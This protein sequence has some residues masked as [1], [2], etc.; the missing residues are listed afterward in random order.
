MNTFIIQKEHANTTEKE[1]V[2]LDGVVA[3]KWVKEHSIARA[4]KALI[5]YIDTAL[6]RRWDT[7]VSAIA[8]SN[9]AKRLLAELA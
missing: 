7:G 5:G 8:V 3:G 2:F 6:N 9:H 1:K 4:K